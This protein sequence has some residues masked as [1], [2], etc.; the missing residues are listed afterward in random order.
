MTIRWLLR[1]IAA[2]SIATAAYM[3]APYRHYII[4][5]GYTLFAPS[6]Y[7]ST[8]TTLRLA[9]I[10]FVGGLIVVAASFLPRKNS[11]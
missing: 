5:S 7:E 9:G 6:V 3:A 4:G 1:G 8:I 11:N 2:L 10:L